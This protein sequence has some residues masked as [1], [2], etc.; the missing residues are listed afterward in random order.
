MRALSLFAALIVARLVTLAVSPL[1]LSFWTPL[2]YIW[3]DVL[4]ALIF[5]ALDALTG[6]RRA[7][8]LV[9]A[10]VV[11]YVAINVPVT[12][13]LS[14]PLTPAMLRASSGPLLDSVRHHATAENLGAALLVITAGVVFA[15][16][17]RQRELRAWRGIALAAL[18][19]AMAGP[20][21]VAR[22]DTVGMHRNAFGALWPAR[23][24][25]RP[26]RE[27]PS[28]VM[29][30]RASPFGPDATGDELASYRGRAAGRNVVMVILES[31]AARYLRVYGA[32]EDPM[33]NLTAL[34]EQSIVFDN[35]YAVYPESIKGLFVTLCSRYPLFAAP[36]G[37][38]ADLPC[39]SLARIAGDAGYR[40]AL[41]HSGRFMYLGMQAMLDDRGFG[42]LEDA[43]HIGGRMD[44]S[45]G[46]DEPST[47]RR[48]LSW[49]DS[50]APHERFFLAYLPIAGHHPYATPEPGPFPLD[51][52]L[53]RYRNALH[54]G[55]AAFG[56]LLR[57]FRARGLEERTL[58]VVFGDHGEAFGQHALNFG[59]T[60]FIYDENVRVPYLIAAPG[61]I[62]DQLR[63]PQT[64]SLIDTAP[65]IL[66]LLGLPLAA[67]FQGSSLLDGGSRMALFFTDYSLGWLGLR[68]ACWKY[69]YELD[70][71]RSK[72]FDLCRDP[73]EIDDQADAHR[74]RTMVYRTHLER[75]IGAGSSPSGLP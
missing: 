6:H 20:V 60:L 3:Q 74:G 11:G 69:L 42:R 27:D 63:V 33:P 48:I 31:T 14:S 34:A 35:A 24:A 15:L 65:T 18:V 10:A 29:T 64:A 68:D 62:H 49:V 7:T 56:E 13:I 55:D 26:Q 53:D 71:H 30:W 50:L 39:P 58:F 36:A 66:D 38:H 25:L 28:M 57:G 43:G 21:A 46:V 73:G 54:Y 23:M 51:T 59:H 8:W 44:S 4:V 37:D 2:A 72:L 40:T 19:V 16:L 32:R 52:E 12:L 17:L 70:S 75:W 22:V 5:A 45:F 1:P 67:D 47:V 61:L 41:F 9:Y